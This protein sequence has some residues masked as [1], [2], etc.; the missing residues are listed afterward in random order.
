MVILG[1]IFALVSVYTY[2][3]LCA[4]V[5]ETAQNLNRNRVA[6][7]LFSIVFTPILGAFMVHC[8]GKNE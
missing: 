8:L 7:L 4:E 6:W 2:F 1:L 3:A 5:S